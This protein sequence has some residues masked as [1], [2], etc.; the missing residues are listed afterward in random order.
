MTFSP[1]GLTAK[2]SSRNP[3]LLIGRGGWA[4]AYAHG[5]G[6]VTRPRKDIVGGSLWLMDFARLHRLLLKGAIVCMCMVAGLAILAVVGVTMDEGAGRLILA[7]LC[8][9]VACVAGASCA[10]FARR[11]PGNVRPAVAALFVTGYAAVMVIGGIWTGSAS[12]GYWRIAGS[13]MLIALG[14][15]QGFNLIRYRVA[16]RYEW[17]RT[18]AVATLIIFV[19]TA[20]AAVWS[21][22][23]E[24]SAT[25]YV[26][27]ISLILAVLFSG[28]VPKLATIHATEADTDTDTEPGRAAARCPRQGQSGD[29]VLEFVSDGIYRDESGVLF[30]VQRLGEVAASERRTDLRA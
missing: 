2:A 25:A 4:L 17:L 16:T 3:L 8:A 18:A 29:L 6:I 22:R 10:T 24:G 21:D 28:I 14:L 1:P 12:P 27:I 19:L 13:L 26:C 15:A 7:H 9:A 11:N 20:L 30:G 5:F 23:A